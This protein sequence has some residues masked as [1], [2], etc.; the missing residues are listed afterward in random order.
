MVAWPGWSVVRRSIPIPNFPSL[1]I[2]YGTPPKS[3]HSISSRT[4]QSIHSTTR[5]SSYLPIRCSS[6]VKDLLQRLPPTRRPGLGAHGPR[7]Q[8]LLK[9]ARH[10]PP[11]P[12]PG[13]L[14]HAFHI[15]DVVVANVLVG[16]KEKTRAAVII[17]AICVKPPSSLVRDHPLHPFG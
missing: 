6:L 10:F 15:A 5:L 8:T 2:V 9:T 12:D 11:L 13:I 16:P 17:Y 4:S 1:T 7:N 3:G 14:G